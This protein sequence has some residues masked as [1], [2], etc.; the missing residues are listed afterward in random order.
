MLRPQSRYVMSADWSKLT[1]GLPHTLKLFS[2]AA[3]RISQPETAGRG[4]AVSLCEQQQRPSNTA[5]RPHAA[6]SSVCHY[7]CHFLVAN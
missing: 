6:F 5:P 1:N 7:W 3:P 2:S 4:E